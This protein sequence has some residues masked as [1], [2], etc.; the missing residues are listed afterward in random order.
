M[1]YCTVYSTSF[2]TSVLYSTYL[3]LVYPA[4]HIPGRRTMLYPPNASV[5]YC[6]HCRSVLCTVTVENM[7]LA[8]VTNNVHCTMRTLSCILYTVHCTLYKFINIKN[9]LPYVSVQYSE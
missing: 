2:K 7:C 5:L 3:R 1:M 9:V 4:V 6:T 8:R